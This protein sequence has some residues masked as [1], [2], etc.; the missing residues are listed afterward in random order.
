MPAFQASASAP[1]TQLF[2]TKFLSMRYMFYHKSISSKTFYKLN[3]LIKGLIRNQSHKA[4]GRLK[5]P[6]QRIIQVL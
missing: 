4:A 1:I 6:W 3:W 2:C 5:K